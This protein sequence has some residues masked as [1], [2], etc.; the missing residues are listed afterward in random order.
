VLALPTGYPVAFALTAAV[1]PAMLAA[2]GGNSHH[3]PFGIN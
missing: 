1:R 2:A 3:G